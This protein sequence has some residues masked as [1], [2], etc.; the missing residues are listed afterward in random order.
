VNFIITFFLG[1]GDGCDNV[2]FIDV[3]DVKKVRWLSGTFMMHGPFVVTHMRMS[4][5]WSSSQLCC[6][7]VSLRK[8]KIDR[9]RL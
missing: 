8:L 1:G 6:N 9:Y 2:S 7:V 3:S 5:E 4:H